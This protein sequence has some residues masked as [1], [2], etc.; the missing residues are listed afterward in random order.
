M[1]YDYVGE[2]V[3]ES[4]PPGWTQHPRGDD[5]VVGHPGQHGRQ[6]RPATL[7]RRNLPSPIE[8]HQRLLEFVVI[9]SMPA[10]QLLDIRLQFSQLL[11]GPAHR[12]QSGHSD[13]EDL[14]RLTDRPADHRGA[15]A[16]SRVGDLIDH[17]QAQNRLPAQ[18]QLFPAS[19]GGHF[20]A[21]F[22]L[23]E[24]ALAVGDGSTRGVSPPCST[25]SS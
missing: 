12:G 17:P 24:V 16:G 7:E 15:P 20:V 21:M 25:G 5:P 6:Q 19:A 1:Q 23:N 9:R 11:H 22:D 14:G 4:L 3:M 2:T 13:Q 18:N 10:P 8:V